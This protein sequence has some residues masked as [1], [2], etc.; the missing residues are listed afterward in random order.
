MTDEATL[1]DDEAGKIT[2]VEE[3]AYELSISEVM[4][5]NVITLSPNLTMLEA[6]DLV[7]L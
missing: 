5:R 3:L 4:T 6:L 2:R 7:E 1:T